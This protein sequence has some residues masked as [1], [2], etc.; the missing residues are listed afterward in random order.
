MRVDVDGFVGY[1]HP[2]EVGLNNRARP[3]VEFRASGGG[4]VAI[5]VKLRE[6]YGSVS[7]PFSKRYF[8]T[9][10]LWDGLPHLRALAERIRDEEKDVKEFTTLHAAQL[11]K[12]SMGLRR[13]YGNEFTLMYLW[14]YVPSETGDEHI[15]ELA[16]FAAVASADINFTSVTVDELLGRVDRDG[17]DKAWLHY[18]TERYSVDTGGIM[19]SMSSMEAE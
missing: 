1:E 19:A 15:T 2:H 5:E 14:H 17:C 12:H 4:H 10:G 16:K 7:N 6:P 11:I 9:P 8:S 18:M 13:S 3:D